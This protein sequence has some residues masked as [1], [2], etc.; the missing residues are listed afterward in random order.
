MLDIF[1]SL[2]WFLT[3]RHL[4]T[5]IFPCGGFYSKFILVSEPAR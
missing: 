1:F 3:Q 4:L 2:A 5:D